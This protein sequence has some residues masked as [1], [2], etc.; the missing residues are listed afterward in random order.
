M[1][2]TSQNTFLKTNGL[3]KT[4]YLNILFFVL[5]HVVWVLVGVYLFLAFIQIYM[6]NLCV[7]SK[8]QKKMVTILDKIAQSGFEALSKEEKRFLFKNNNNHS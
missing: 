8:K 5:G 7:H 4:I 3:P 2:K 1:N 6:G